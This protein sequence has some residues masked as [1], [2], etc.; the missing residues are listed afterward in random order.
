MATIGGWN[1]SNTAKLSTY[2]DT[3]V[4]DY[5]TYLYNL[6]AELGG[7]FIGQYAILGL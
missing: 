2:P 3:D 5:A 4:E 7:N 1:I 6:A